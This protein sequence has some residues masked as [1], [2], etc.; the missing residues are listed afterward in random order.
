MN[1]DYQ[2]KRAPPPVYTRKMT[3]TESHWDYLP[4]LVQNY[5][6]D[7]AARAVHR[8]R[9]KA[10]CRSINLYNEWRSQQNSLL[11]MYQEISILSPLFI[12]S[13]IC[14]KCF[15][16]FSPEIVLSK[17][18]SICRGLYQ[19]FECLEDEYDDEYIDEPINF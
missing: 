6:E 9:M 1:G 14:P 4:D 12:D 7:L 15:K 13:Q 11:E 16:I 10:V 17:H 5:I 8:E 3:F 18:L 19:S 2:L